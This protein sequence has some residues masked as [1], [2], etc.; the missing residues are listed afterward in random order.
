MPRRPRTLTLGAALAAAPLSEF[1]MPSLAVFSDDEALAIANML[2]VGLTP[3]LRAGLDDAA[4]GL[5]VA[6]MLSVR[7]RQTGSWHLLADDPELGLTPGPDTTPELVALLRSQLTRLAVDPNGDDGFALDVIREAAREMAS[8]RGRVGP[9]GDH[10]L[11]LFAL[12]VVRTARSAEADLWLPQPEQLVGGQAPKIGLLPA[13]LAT[14]RCAGEALAD[15]QSAAAETPDADIRAAFPA[16]L[17]TRA[18]ELQNISARSMRDR[19]SVAKN[20]TDPWK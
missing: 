2:G 9:K 12:V 16:K 17:Q 5:I 11:A 18:Q 14:A 3:A 6:A 7:P 15:L 13:A 1:G 20:T 19:L 8:R 4:T 10:A